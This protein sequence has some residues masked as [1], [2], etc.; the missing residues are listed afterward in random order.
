MSVGARLTL[1]VVGIVA[2]GIAVL[3]IVVTTMVSRELRPALATTSSAA[4]APSS[5]R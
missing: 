2:L 1:L 5:P 4:I 3:T